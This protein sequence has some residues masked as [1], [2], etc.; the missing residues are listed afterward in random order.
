MAIVL[1]GLGLGAALALFAVARHRVR[2]L[3]PI[4]EAV[5][6]RRLSE[7]GSGRFRV[8]GRVVAVETTSSLVDGSPCVFLE[9]AEYRTV[10][11]E[12]VPLLREV[13][14]RTV[15]HP[16][17]L[18]DG[19]GR[20]LVDPG[21]AVV[22]AVTITEDAGLS[23]ERR[24]R[25]GEEVDLVATFGPVRAEAG[26]PYRAGHTAWQPVAD[27]CGPP[28]LSYRTEPDMVRAH[29]EVAA[30]LRGAGVLTLLLTALL[31]SLS[32]L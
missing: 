4:P 2:S 24:L 30:F 17:Y 12:L 8:R 27:G 16:F 11:S 15:A 18:D 1:F 21:A 14:H 32:L 3:T 10:G 6:F 13:G 9:Q 25:A 23:A 26:G 7:L 5:P 29:D 20:L 19:S 22:E 31:G 28:R